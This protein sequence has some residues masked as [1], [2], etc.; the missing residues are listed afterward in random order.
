MTQ[1]INIVADKIK[2]YGP[3]VDGGYTITL[4]VGEYMVDQ[5]ADLMK[6]AKAGNI[7]VI[8]S[9]YGKTGVQTNRGAEETS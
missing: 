3:K 5:I 4:E 1:E 7:D 8:F 2:V 9:E 6:L